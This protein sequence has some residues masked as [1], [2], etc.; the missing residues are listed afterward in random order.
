MHTY[1]VCVCVCP[2]TRVHARVDVCGER[3]K[4]KIE[5][6]YVLVSTP[7]SW[8]RSIFCSNIWYLTLVPDTELLYP[9][10]FPG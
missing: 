8:H 10:E 2:R 1:I 6:I 4:E 7:G 3:E 9:L 5:N